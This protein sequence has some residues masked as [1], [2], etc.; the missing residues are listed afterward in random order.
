MCDCGIVSLDANALGPDVLD[1]MRPRCGTGA[2]TNQGVFRKGVVAFGHRPAGIIDLSPARPPADGES[3]WRDHARLQRRIYNYVELDAISAKGY[4]YRSRPNGDHH[5]PLREWATDCVSKFNGR[6]AFALWTAA[7]AACSVRA[8][9]SAKA[10][11]YGPAA[12]FASSLRPRSKRFLCD[13]RSRVTQSASW[14]RYLA[15]I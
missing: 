10:F 11:Y 3:R 4:G 9:D 15:T 1:Q 8:I 12:G 6:F 13:R 7:S 14:Y 2:R 5:S